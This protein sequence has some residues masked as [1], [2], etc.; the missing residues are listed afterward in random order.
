M[1]EFHDDYPQ[2]EFMAHHSEEE[3]KVMR[4]K[5]WRVF[6]IMLGITLLELFVGFKAEDFGW[7]TDQR[8][9]SLGM[10]FFFIIF[11]I[12]KAGYI[13]LS[14]MHLGH[15]KKALKWIIIA[16]YATFIVYLACMASIGEGEYTMEHRA[17]MDHNVV[18]QATEHK[19][20]G[21][22]QKEAEE[23]VGE[24]HHEKES[25]HHEGEKTEHE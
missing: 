5:L 1:S 16:P 24:E 22:K 13:V 2:Y 4:K 7:L 10:K 20:P 8:G 11:T 6:W 14:F 19:T 12:V 17:P 3:G 15:E 23:G 18:E 25:E 9:T 21:Y